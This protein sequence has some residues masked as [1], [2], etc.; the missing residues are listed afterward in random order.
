[1]QAAKEKVAGYRDALRESRADTRIMEQ[2]F[3]RIVRVYERDARRS[4]QK[5]V[6][7]ADLKKALNAEAKKHWQDVK[8]RRTA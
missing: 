3:L 4:G 5:D 1:M 2:E 7:I 8:C 6:Q